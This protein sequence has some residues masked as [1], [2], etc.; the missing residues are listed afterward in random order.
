[1]GMQKELGYPE[2]DAK[3]DDPDWMREQLRKEN[4][5]PRENANFFLDPSHPDF[6]NNIARRSV[7]K[8]P[9]ED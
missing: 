4:E 9:I 2:Y 1:M 3:F 6:F 5:D 8:G 7:R